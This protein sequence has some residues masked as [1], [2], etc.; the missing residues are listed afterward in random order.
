VSAASLAQLTDS[1]LAGSEEV[2]EDPYPFYARLRSEAP[3]FVHRNVVLVS[4]Y[5]D[6]VALVHDD[7]LS[8]RKQETKKV[9]HELASLDANDAELGRTWVGFIGN[10]LSA[11]DPPDHTRRRRLQQ[12][13]FLP[14]Q[15]RSVIDYV[16]STTDRLLDAASE[17]GTFDFVADFAYPLPMLVIAHMMGVPEADMPKIVRWSQ[18]VGAVQ[19]LGLSQIREHGPGIQAFIGYVE[20]TIA[21]RRRTP[22]QDL[23]D[24]LIAAEEE[25]DKLSSREL[26]ITFFNLLFSG[27]ETT[28]TLLTNGM[29]GLLQHPDQWRLV[30]E[31]PEMVE[32]AVEELLRWVSPVQMITRVTRAAFDFSG[33]HIPADLSVKLLLGSAN[34]SPDKFA[35]PDRLDMQ[36]EDEA[37][38]LFFGTG[39]HY[40]MGGAL[41]RLEAQTAFRTIAGRFPDI[42]LAGES[43]QWRRNPLMRRVVDLP[44]AIP[45]AAAA[46]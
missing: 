22:Q 23:L 6:I 12:H 44:L 1:F 41:A 20:D 32:P 4:R 26:T 19:G 46:G 14:R 43:L 16:Q 31:D 5:D 17:R 39:P 24:L 40:C 38:G 37:K 30:C 35:E 29:L 2:V 13:G 42:Q 7:R 10:F 11:T 3:V 21:A 33:G 18:D 28:T 15:L 36:R 9:A 25:G 8:N 34:H 27:H 45:S